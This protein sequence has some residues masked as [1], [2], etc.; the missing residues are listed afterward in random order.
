MLAAVLLFARVQTAAVPQ[1]STAVPYAPAFRGDYTGP[2]A[3]LNAHDG[4]AFGSLALDPLLA[5][6]QAWTTDRGGLAYRA[7][8]PVLGWLVMLTSFGSPRV[9]AWTLMGWTAIGIGMMA[10]AAT[11]LCRAWGR[12]DTWPPLL[13]LL[14]GVIGLL[15]FA[16]LSDG[17]ATGLVLLGLVLWSRKRDGLAVTVFCIAALTRESTL[18]VPL[19]LLLAA[20][21]TRTR[22]LVLPFAVYAGW[23][24]LVWLR[25]HALPTAAPQSHLGLPLVGLIRALPGWSWVEVACAASVAVLGAVAYRRAPSRE[26]RVLVVASAL[27][28]STMQ[29][30]VW[31]SW[32]FTRPLLPVTVVGACLLARRIGRDARNDQGGTPDV[33]AQAYR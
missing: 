20:R 15:A 25:L 16:G 10:A 13:L 3:V 26:V 28:A 8:R 17:L 27:F 6:P 30:A 22:R 11:F 31:R 5:H 9:A 29:E 4:Q 32:D 7:A 14:P 2:G 24:G 18:L 23:I 12:D 33:P 21:S 1:T 19:A